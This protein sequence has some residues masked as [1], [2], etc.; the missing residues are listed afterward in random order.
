M[1]RFLVILEDGRSVNVTADGY[2]EARAEAA[3]FGKVHAVHVYGQSKEN[4]KKMNERRK[5]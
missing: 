3:K 2:K 5:K 1:P 4:E